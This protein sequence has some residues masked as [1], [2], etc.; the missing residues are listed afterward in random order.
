MIL[1]YRVMINEAQDNIVV[2]DTEKEKEK[3]KAALERYYNFNHENVIQMHALPLSFDRKSDP[4]L[5]EGWNSK[6]VAIHRKNNYFQFIQKLQVLYLTS[7]PYC[8]ASTFIITK[9]GLYCFRNHL[10]IIDWFICPIYLFSEELSIKQM[11]MLDQLKKLDLFDALPKIKIF[12]KTTPTTKSWVHQYVRGNESTCR[13]FESIIRLI[14]GTYTNGPW[15][16]LDGFFGMYYH[17]EKGELTEYFPED[18][19][20]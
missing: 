17:S 16:P 11:Y 12:E 5:C 3:E 2:I 14:P 9:H 19:S 13:R 7:I 4:W 8:S 20:Q 18:V 10:N 1:F 15:R 6:E